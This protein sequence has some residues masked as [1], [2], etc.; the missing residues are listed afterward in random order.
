MN[1]G[2]HNIPENYI[3][4]ICDE[5]M[6]EYRLGERHV[7]QDAIKRGLRNA[8]GTG[9]L[10]GETGI[11]SVRGYYMEDGSRVPM[12]GELYYRG[13]SVSDIID[14]HQRNRTFGF[15]EVAYLLL[16]GKLP[17]ATQNE[18]FNMIL[19]RARKLPD[20][21]IE[22]ILLKHPGKNIMNMLSRC[23]LALYTYDDRAEDESVEN[24]MRQSIE[25]IG[26]FP[27]IVATAYAIKRHRFD[28]KSLYIHSPKEQLSVPENFLRMLRKDKVYTKEE[29]LLLDLML[30]LHAEHGGGNN[31]TF[32]CRTLSSA[33]TDT[34]SA[35]S[36]AI[37][38]L[39]GALHGGANAKVIEM[40]E[41]I[42]SEVK[43][44]DNENEV[45]AYLDKLLDKK[46]G[47]RSGKIFGLGHAVYTISDPRAEII[48]KYAR[49]MAEEKGR[50]RDFLFIETVERL[51]LQK[52][53]E[54]KKLDIPMCANVDLYSGFVYATLGIPEELYT[55]LFALARIAG[56]CAHRLEEVIT[57]DRIMRPAYRASV[58]KHPYAQPEERL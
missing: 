18:F 15:E 32:T 3:K 16:L 1:N 29:A 31:S 26:R 38:S 54:R 37:N 11:G 39:K 30:I 27:A 51:G 10:I 23:V 24:L 2:D 48:K 33:R 53:A 41:F 20:G 50:L 42:K 22:D 52:I 28:E 13:I 7:A 19:S 49:A 47:D 8:D 46:A 57:C 43:D 55:P 5:A 25:L 17:N 34:Y 9:V 12:P 21:F 35:I 4:T 14:S 44:T 58:K 36:G 45:S 40:L 56:W 6:S